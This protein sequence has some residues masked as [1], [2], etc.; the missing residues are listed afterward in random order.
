MSEKSHD[1]RSS[2]FWRIVAAFIMGGC[3]IIAAIV[4][5]VLPKML[6]YYNAEGQELNPSNTAQIESEVQEQKAETVLNPSNTAQIESEA[7]EQKAETVAPDVSTAYIRI[8]NVHVTPVDFDIASSF[9]AEIANTSSN[10]EANGVSAMVDFGKAKIERCET[11]PKDLSRNED[12]YILELNIGKILPKQTIYINCHISAPFFEKIL[13]TGKN[14]S[15]PKTFTQDQI[16]TATQS[17]QVEVNPLGAF[18]GLLGCIS[19]IFVLLVLRRI[20]GGE[21]GQFMG[22]MAAVFI[23]FTLFWTAFIVIALAFD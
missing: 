4:Y 12:I 2:N 17:I 1:R 5:V 21:L 20:L 22:G 3:A 10:T 14:I 9:Y 8:E 18:L 15:Y 11:K 6:D 23:I 16:E 13:V 7:Q 19:A